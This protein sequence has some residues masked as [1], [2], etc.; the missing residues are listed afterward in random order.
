MLLT[1]NLQELL[2]QLRAIQWHAWTSHW[3][4]RGPQFYSDHLLLQRIYEGQD[5]GDA[6]VD[7]NAQVD[8]LGERLVAAFG[9]GAIQAGVVE[10]RAADL[11]DRALQRNPD[12]VFAAALDLEK[13]VQ[14]QIAVTLKQLS[15][16][17]I[18]W[19]NFLRTLADERSEVL[20]LLQR[21]TQPGEF[22]VAPY[23]RANPNTSSG[24]TT[25]QFL[26]LAGLCGLLFLNYIY[27]KVVRT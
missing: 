26:L 17:E 23:G 19:D 25:G 8:K 24:A 5:E 11:V 16:K 1:A 21:R 10:R 4:A 9:A 14:S 27:P 22:H 12:N 2:A 6:G 20:Y 18:V 13:Q 15:A 3:V 7:I